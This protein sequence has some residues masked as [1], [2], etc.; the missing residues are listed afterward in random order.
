M[1]PHAFFAPIP[2]DIMIRVRTFSYSLA[3]LLA[4]FTGCSCESEKASM[5]NPEAVHQTYSVTFDAGTKKTS[6]SARFRFGGATGTNLE[7]DGVAKV[8]HSSCELK[9]ANSFG[10]YYVGATDGYQPQHEFTY[11]DTAGK[12]YTNAIRLAAIDFAADMPV[13]ISRGKPLVVRFAGDA[14]AV[15]ER[16]SLSLL[17][18]TQPQAVNKT[19]DVSQ[20]GAT[21]IVMSE[22]D[23]QPFADG[24]ATLSLS[25]MSNQ[26]LQAATSRGGGISAT[27]SAAARK[28][29]IVK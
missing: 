28:I 15:G 12:V 6:A 3:I 13:E 17:Q 21:Q 29:K 16:V 26:S 27:Y 9:R 11:T 20:P 2:E 19:V 22:I 24:D 25:R 10:V 4:T 18:P 1:S 14:V 7:L 5:A 23:L 8:V